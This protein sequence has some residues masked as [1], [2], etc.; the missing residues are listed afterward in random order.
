M[1]ILELVANGMKFFEWNLDLPLLQKQQVL[2]RVEVPSVGVIKATN[3]K[4]KHVPIFCMASRVMLPYGS[5]G[6]G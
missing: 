6:F 2:C 3:I 5:A 4:Y 1:V